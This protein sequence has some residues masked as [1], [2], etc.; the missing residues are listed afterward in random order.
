MVS[1]FA[2]GRLHRA[3]EHERAG[4]ELEDPHHLLDWLTNGK[5]RRVDGVVDPRMETT[6]PCR[7]LG[8]AHRGG[9]GDPRRLEASVVNAVVLSGVGGWRLDFFALTPVTTPGLFVPASAAFASASS[10][11]LSV[12]W[13]ASNE[14]SG[15]LELR[16][17]LPVRL[18]DV[19]AALELALDD[20]AQGRALD[21]ADREEVGAEAAG[22]ERDGP[23]QRRAPDQVDVLPGGAGVGE[24]VG[25]ARRGSRTR[26]RSRPW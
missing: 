10:Q 16:E 25:E 20:Q 13:C 17:H 4:L 11:N 14:P 24:V 3:V 6:R 21:A 23:G 22:G 9:R 15:M 26:A 7:V 12:A 1:F 8:Q 19:G 2:A 5:R 18:R